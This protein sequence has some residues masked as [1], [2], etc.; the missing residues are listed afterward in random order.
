MRFNFSRLD[1]YEGVGL[2]CWVD[3]LEAYYTARGHL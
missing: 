1:M 3:S 2:S